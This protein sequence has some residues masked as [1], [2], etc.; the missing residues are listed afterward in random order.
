MKFLKEYFVFSSSERRGIFLFSLLLF[1]LVVTYF[2][3]PYFIKNE[4]VVDNE[5]RNK[6]NAL[7]A[8]NK[9]EITEVSRLEENLFE[10]NPNTISLQELLALGLSQKQ[11][12]TII[13][14]RAKGGRFYKKEDFKK[15]YSI[16]NKLYDKLSPY[17]VFNHQIEK[18]I[19]IENEALPVQDSLFYFN[20]NTVSLKEL[21]LLGF[22][23]K[24]AATF[25][26]FRNKGG[27][28]YTPEDV[29][30]VYGITDNLYQKIVSY[31]EI[32]QKE[33]ISLANNDFII[34]INSATAEEFKQISGIGEKISARIVTYRDKLGGFY[35]VEHLAE[36]YGIELDLINKNKSHFTIDK[37]KIKKI[38][39]NKVSID[40]FYKHPYI[41]FNDARKIV[42]FREVHGLFTTVNE[43]KTN[44]LVKDEVYS[45]IVNYLIL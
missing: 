40:E 26:N 7:L 38:N 8:Q 16:S 24:Q 14:Y 4:S 33:N 30:K 42:N 18:E 5:F 37:N 45:K 29:K 23:D 11:A 36:V 27:K 28:F 43:I 44:D 13:N 21:T 1:G 35:S 34:E 22:S 19:T 41:S 20:P 17:I 3:L 12:Q 10:F 6:V 31:I 32:P 39:L 25:V 9:E 2:L 15:I